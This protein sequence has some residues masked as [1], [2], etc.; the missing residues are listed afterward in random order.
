MPLANSYNPDVKGFS[1][2]SGNANRGFGDASI[3]GAVAPG[4]LGQASFFL[5]RQSRIEACLRRSLHGPPSRPPARPPDDPVRPFARQAETLTRNMVSS[6]TEEEFAQEW[7]FVTVWIGGNDMCSRGTT[8]TEC[9]IPSP[10]VVVVPRALGPACVPRQQDSL[11]CHVSV[12]LTMAAG[13]R[14]ARA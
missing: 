1:L 2:G 6:L 5:A 4:M 9:A 3:S 14:A 10:S 11:E 8:A 7:K 13:G 12:L